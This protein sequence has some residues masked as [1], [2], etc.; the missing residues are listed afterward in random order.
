MTT[1]KRSPTHP[2]SRGPQPT[3]RIHEET[4]AKLP[5]IAACPRCGASYRKGRWTWEKAP[6]GSYEHVCPACEREATDEPAGVL[7]VA[8]RFATAHRKEIENL[9]RNVEARE[10]EAHP[11]KR[12]LRIE[13]E[14]DGFRVTATNAKL[15]ETFG[16]A[17]RQAYEG[18][19]DHPGTSA[20]PRRFARIRWTRD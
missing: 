11:L 7:H 9:L 3:R 15:V 5:E 17:L 1:R 2:V 8:G 16:H 13:D 6:V 19:L 20:E 12:I 18:E 14:E 4:P 10:R